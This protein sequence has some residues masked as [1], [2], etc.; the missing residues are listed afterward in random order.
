MAEHD[1]RPSSWWHTYRQ[2][3]TKWAVAVVGAIL[4]LVG[5]AGL[6]LPGPGLLL[7][8][9]GVAVLATQFEWAERRVDLVR[10]K[11]L[12]AAAA[13]VETWPRI[14][15]STLGAIWLIGIGIFWGLAVDVQI[16][17]I[18]ILGPELPFQGWATGGTLIGSGI[19]ALGLLVYSYRRFRLGREDVHEV[20]ENN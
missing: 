14:V 2:L 12:L 19:V 4:L 11:A 15:A 10:D 17:E 5:I 16:P 3:I 13:G 6:I 9:F 7:M 20:V 18:W 1:H 8:F